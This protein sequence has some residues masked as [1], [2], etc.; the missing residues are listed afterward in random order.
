MQLRP[1]KYHGGGAVPAKEDDERSDE[2]REQLSGQAD[3]CAKAGRCATH[4]RVV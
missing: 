3:E 1:R 2:G 4:T